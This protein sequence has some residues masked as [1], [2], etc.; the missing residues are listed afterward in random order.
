[1]TS[2]L[3]SLTWA[4]DLLLVIVGFGLII[5]IHELG[6]FLAA[7]WAGIRVMAFAIGFGPAALSFRRGMGWRRGSSEPEYLARLKHDGLSSAELAHR[8]V[9]STE[10]RLN[11]IPFGGYVKMLG[12]DDADPTAVSTEPDGYQMCR[13]WKRMIVISAGVIMNVIAAAILFVIVYL[14]GIQKEPARVGLVA[15][16]GPAAQAVALN[17]GPLGVTESGLK[18]GDDVVSVNGSRPDS[19]DNLILSTAMAGPGEVLEFEVRRAGVPEPLRFDIEPTPGP[20]TGLL[21]IGIEPARSNQIVSSDR[22]SERAQI[23]KVLTMSGLEGVDAGDHLVSIDGHRVDSAQALVLAARESR[24]RP[25]TLRFS[26]SGGETSVVIQPRAQLQIGVL[27]SEAKTQ[28]LVPHLLGFQPVMRVGSAGEAES[29]GLR[30]G[31]VFLRLG[32]IEYPSVAQGRA[33]IRAH[34]GGNIEAVVQRID[35]DGNPREIPLSLRVGRSDPP[36]VGFLPDDTADQSTLMAAPLSVATSVEHGAPQRACAAAG[37]VH[38]PG[39]SI[40]RVAG[41]PVANFTEVRER[42]REATREAFEREEETAHVPLELKLGYAH[43]ETREIATLTLSR[44]DL[45]ELHA[46]SWSLPFSL[47]LFELEHFTLKAKGPVSAIALGLRETRR[48]MLST[49]LTFARLFQGTVKVEHLKGP[50]GIAHLGTRIA[51]RGFVWL[52]FFLAL[53]SVNLAVINF[54]PLPIVDGGQFLM[55]LYEQIRGRPVPLAVQSVFTLVGLAMIGAL[56]LVVT[57]NDLRNLFVG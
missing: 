35:A 16:D 39:V 31:D 21:E 14:V 55:L 10:Y 30:D 18:P 22:A 57:Y 28:V 9:H 15:L 33:E 27:A 44:A 3:S 26:G 24:G 23:A 47:A 20:L 19:F 11:W 7:R 1:M 43:A 37:V 25:L 41:T 8:G 38:A 36:T 2:V 4:L 56:F 51:E 29:M 42:L 32:A 54:L 34:K 45:E 48:V 53:I 40:E 6:H 5:F 50:V 46:L 49:Y 13:P 52:L 12:Q 17:G